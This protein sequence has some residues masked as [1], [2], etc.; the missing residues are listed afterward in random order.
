M[1]PLISEFRLRVEH[2]SASPERRSEIQ[3]EL[4]NEFN[5]IYR[6]LSPDVGVWEKCGK[7]RKSHKEVM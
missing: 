6:A 2:A 7:R 1:S 4:L 3:S 5:L